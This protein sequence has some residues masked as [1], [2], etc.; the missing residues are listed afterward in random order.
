MNKTS[1]FDFLQF[2]LTATDPNIPKSKRLD[3]DDVYKI[4]HEMSKHPRKADVYD[5]GHNISAKNI[6]R[7]QK[8]PTTADYASN[9]DPSEIKGSIKDLIPTTKGLDTLRVV[10]P[11]NIRRGSRKD[12]PQAIQTLKGV[13]RNVEE[14]YV[15]F[16][17]PE[18]DRAIL[19]VPQE[20]WPEMLKYIRDGFDAKR[21]FGFNNFTDFLADRNLTL[22]QFNKFNKKSQRNLRVKFN[23][24]KEFV[25]GKQQLDKH[26]EWIRELADEYLEKYTLGQETGIERINTQQQYLEKFF[27]DD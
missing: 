7:H 11:G 18:I 2:A 23:K 17:N 19:R 3:I 14:E 24:Q 26:E 25:I 5:I 12:L 16:L 1:K 9:L 6:A 8:L 27:P 13:S 21:S 22:S 4:A 15:R 20:A 10:E